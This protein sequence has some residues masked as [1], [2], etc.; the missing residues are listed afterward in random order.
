M[1]SPFSPLY[2]DWREKKNNT[3]VIA[4]VKFGINNSFSFND[5]ITT[6]F[7]NKNYPIIIQI[8]KKQIYLPFWKNSFNSILKIIGEQNQFCISFV[9]AFIQISPQT[10][11]FLTFIILLQIKTEPKRISTNIILYTQMLCWYQTDFN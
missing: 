5:P 2:L 10:H 3:V 9:I 8:H 6:Y 11:K 7:S 4:K 1:S